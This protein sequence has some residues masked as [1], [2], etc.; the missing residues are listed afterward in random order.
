MAEAQGAEPQHRR[1][2]GG[3][4]KFFAEHG[5]VAGPGIRRIKGD[6]GFDESGLSKHGGILTFVYVSSDTQYTV[7]RH[8]YST[9]P[10]R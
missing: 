7:D 5:G 3:K 9:Q 10:F 4:R 8:D 1:L 6:I 2:K